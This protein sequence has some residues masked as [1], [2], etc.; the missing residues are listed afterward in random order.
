MLQPLC[1]SC[2][3]QAALRAAYAWA[4]TMEMK[5]AHE[6]KS[7]RRAAG[8]ES[9]TFDTYSAT[10]AEKLKWASKSMGNGV[11]LMIS[12][13]ARSVPNGPVCIFDAQIE[14][15]YVLASHTTSAD[16]LCSHAGLRIHQLTLLSSCAGS[17]VHLRDR[18]WLL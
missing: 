7:I 4:K 3:E 8:A 14:R 17:F 15:L 11:S 6:S 16:I 2:L 12:R 18:R 13:L 5:S 9:P 1:G 10:G